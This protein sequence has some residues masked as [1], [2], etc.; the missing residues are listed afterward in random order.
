MSFKDI[1]IGT[2]NMGDKK[3]GYNDKK[4]KNPTQLIKKIITKKFRYFDCIC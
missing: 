1:I 2:A 3:Y 4:V